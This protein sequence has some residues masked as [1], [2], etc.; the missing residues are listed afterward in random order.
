MKIKYPLLFGLILLKSTF[1]AVSQEQCVPIGMLCEYLNNPLGID[2]LHPRL[3]WH[4]D[5][6]REGA[7]L[8]A[9]RVLS[10]QTL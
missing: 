7:K 8:E 3:Q 10:V 1:V 4:L 5:D 9:Y 2:V 6:V